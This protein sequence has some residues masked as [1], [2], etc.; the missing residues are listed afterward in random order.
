MRVWV[1]VHAEHALFFSFSSDTL[2]PSIISRVDCLE[3]SSYSDHKMVTVSNPILS[4]IL[5]T[6]CLYQI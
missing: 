6:S 3:C 4:L 1:Y 5:L 2:I